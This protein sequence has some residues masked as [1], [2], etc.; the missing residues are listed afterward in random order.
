[1]FCYL[2]LRF[3][4]SLFD[5]LFIRATKRKKYFPKPEW[6][7]K[8]A[9]QT[10]SSEQAQYPAC[11]YKE[12]IRCCTLDISQWPMFE[13]WS[14]GVI[15][16]SLVMLLTCWEASWMLTTAWNC[17]FSSHCFCLLKSTWL[18]KLVYVAAEFNLLQNWV[19]CFLKTYASRKSSIRGHNLEV[20][21]CLRRH[22]EAP[23]SPWS[24]SKG[25]TWFRWF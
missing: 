14:V 5:I 19:Q 12:N 2:L 7:L 17:K 24:K 15:L 21:L 23:A 9:D 18:G 22:Q 11:Q 13:S 10:G 1:M 16:R 3:L 20:R 4:V 25:F 6:Q 8:N